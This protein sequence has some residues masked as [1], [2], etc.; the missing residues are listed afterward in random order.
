MFSTIQEVEVFF[1]ER[2]KLG[3]KPGLERITGLLNR[4]NNP[5][6]HFKAIHIAGTNGK[7]S[8]LHFI[9]AALMANGYE[10][11][12]FTSPSFTGL[13]GHIFLNDQQLSEQA[14]LEWMNRLFPHI[15]E[16]DKANLAPTEFE[17]L[18]ALAFS[19]FAEN[20]EIVLIE[21]GMGGR[22]DTTNVLQ[23]ILSIIT[24]IALDHTD[25]LGGSEEEIAWH[26]AGIIKKAIPVIIGNV[27]EEAF[28]VIKEEARHKH[29][30]YYRLGIDFNRSQLNLQMKGEHQLD[31]VSLAIQAVLI[32][33]GNGFEMDVEKGIHQMEKTMLPGRFEQIQSNPTIILDAAHN[34]DG[35]KAFV[36]TANELF[37]DAERH[38]IVA[39]FRDKATEEMLDLLTEQFD[40]VTLT[41]FDHPR[42]WNLDEFQGNTSV[43]QIDSDYQAVLERTLQS[44]SVYFITGSLHFITEIRHYLLNQR[45]KL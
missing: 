8:T 29:A 44:D 12:V 26:K 10:V 38:V 18:T 6:K 17:I 2:K 33:K 15:R 28:A 42:A 19:F 4:L 41:S 16:M 3:M 7:G 9:K 11:G 32:L 36:Q 20:G 35:I 25:Y 43:D 24:S 34:P 37:P 30:P 5:E 27:S 39:M 1:N 45:K 21:T 14:L 13:G 40:H 31:N 22:F 23:P